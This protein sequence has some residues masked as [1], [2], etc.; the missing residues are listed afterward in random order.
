MTSPDPKLILVGRVSG[1]FGVRGEVRLSSYTAEPL[2]LARYGALLGEDGA[3]TLT[4]TS[5]RPLK[6]GEIAVRAREVETREQADAL[7]GLR[8]YIARDVLPEPEEDE[9]Y[10][11][12]LI[13]LEARDGDDAVLGRVKS[14]RNFGAGDILEIVPEGGGPTWYL[15]FTRE[16]APQIRIAE[17]WL[18]A[19][20]PHEIEATGPDT[21]A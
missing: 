14:V 10:L 5:A 12:D 16:A 17:G 15:P 20:R 9:F 4:I 21:E 18:R 3:P 11:A 7:R 8:L 6:A 2:A 13:G 19:I 1:G